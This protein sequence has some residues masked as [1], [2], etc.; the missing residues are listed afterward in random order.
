MKPITQRSDAKLKL[1][2]CKSDCDY[3]LELVVDA[4]L[5]SEMKRGDILKAVTASCIRILRLQMSGFDIPIAAKTLK[6]EAARVAAALIQK[7]TVTPE[8]LDAVPPVGK[9]RGLPAAVAARLAA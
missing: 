8:L 3:L 1:S 2:I 9:R 4:M 6:V 5:A 7:L